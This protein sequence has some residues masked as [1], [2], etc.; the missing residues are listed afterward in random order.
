MKTIAFIPARGGSQSIPRK[1]IKPL[2]GKPL[3]YWTVAALAGAA[4]IDEIMVATKFL[5][6]GWHR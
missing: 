5:L 4:A 6:R 2:C 3:I 1:N